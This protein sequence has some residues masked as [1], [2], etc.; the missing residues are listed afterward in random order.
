MYLQKM[1]NA[2]FYFLLTSFSTA[3]HDLVI[4]ADFLIMR[5]MNW[6][7]WRRLCLPAYQAKTI[8]LV[9][10]SKKQKPAMISKAE[11]F[12]LAELYAVV[13]VF[14]SHL[15]MLITSLKP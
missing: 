1:Q 9:K 14:S 3:A 7:L 5:I 11:C 13:Y 10:Y 15:I 4:Q 12:S 6:N 2:H 8:K